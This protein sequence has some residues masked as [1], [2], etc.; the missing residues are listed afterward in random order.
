VPFIQRFG[1]ALNLTPHFHTLVLDGVYAGTASEPGPF[2]PLPPPE[3]EDVAR[4]LVGTARRILRRLERKGIAMDNDPIADR[5]V[6][7]AVG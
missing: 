7:I 3:T 5:D 2:A 6:G 4:V 1:S